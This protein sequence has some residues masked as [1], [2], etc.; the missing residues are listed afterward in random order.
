MLADAIQPARIENVVAE[1]LKMS[2]KRLMPLLNVAI[3]EWL[4]R[5]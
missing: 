1:E 5:T 3:E 4:R 2:E